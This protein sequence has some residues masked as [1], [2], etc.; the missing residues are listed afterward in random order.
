MGS[1]TELFQLLLLKYINIYVY[2]L[3]LV[4]KNNLQ[5]N[6]LVMKNDLHVND[7]VND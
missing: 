4:I 7:R 3:K 6:D 1:L 5:V 2:I